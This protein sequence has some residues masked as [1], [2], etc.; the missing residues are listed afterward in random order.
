MQKSWPQWLAQNILPLRSRVEQA[1]AME[2]AP[3]H[4]PAQDNYIKHEPA[5][6]TGH[7]EALEQLSA[8]IPQSVP[9]ENGQ[10]HAPQVR[11]V[12]NGCQ[13]VILIR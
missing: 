12:K 1:V 13:F 4:Q 3:P 6:S 5:V 11:M 7:A 9:P 2:D 8:A 10:V